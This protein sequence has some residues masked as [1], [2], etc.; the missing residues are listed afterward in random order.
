[1]KRTRIQKQEC[2]D[3]F[4][5]VGEPQLPL[6]TH[7]SLIFLSLSLEYKPNAMLILCSY[8]CH[9]HVLVPVYC[10]ADQQ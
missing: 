10:F 7:S 5:L 8:S 9:N 6:E 3:A 4:I 2:T 1:M